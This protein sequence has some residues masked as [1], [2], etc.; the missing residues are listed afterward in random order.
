MEKLKRSLEEALVASKAAKMEN[1]RL[2]K[3]NTT[4]KVKLRELKSKVGQIENL[5]KET[6]TSSESSA[7]ALRR[8]TYKCARLEKE[9][10]RSNHASRRKIASLRASIKSMKLRMQRYSQWYEERRARTTSNMDDVLSIVMSLE[11]KISSIEDDPP[12]LLGRLLKVLNRSVRVWKDEQSDTLL[13]SS[14]NKGADSA[15][16]GEDISKCCNPLLRDAT[17][18]MVRTCDDLER[19]ALQKQEKI[20]NLQRELKAAKLRADNATNIIRQYRTAVER[21]RKRAEIVQEALD[22]SERTNA[23]LRDALHSPP[24]LKTR[25]SRSDA[26]QSKSKKVSSGTHR[27]KPNKISVRKANKRTNRRQG[28]T[29]KSSHSGTTQT[30]PYATADTDSFADISPSETEES[31]DRSSVVSNNSVLDHVIADN[32]RPLTPIP[33]ETAYPALNE[34]VSDISA[35]LVSTIA[36]T[37]G[38][39]ALVVDSP[40]L[41][42][43]EPTTVGI[44]ND[45]P[46]TTFQNDISLLDR[47]IRELKQSLAEVGL[48]IGC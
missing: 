3:E 29:K 28:I 30:V 7:E 5:T 48:E 23:E 12:T 2:R 16:H 25:K 41:S 9:L 17:A 43:T 27:Y 22:E 18:T 19:D 4:L 44:P 32:F 34:S 26:F 37:L 10:R 36:D 21:N 6:V 40:S 42:R 13:R 45:A 11:D 46:S 38:R 35:A 8:T 33:E 1:K 31:P 47:D 24:E 39:D 20:N 14:D 15:S